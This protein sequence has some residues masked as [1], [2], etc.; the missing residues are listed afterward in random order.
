MRKISYN[1]LK[2]LIVS[3]AVYAEAAEIEKASFMFERITNYLEEETDLNYNHR[4]NSMSIINELM[5]RSDNTEVRIRSFAL[6]G[7]WALILLLSSLWPFH[8]SN[9]AKREREKDIFALIERWQVIHR[10]IYLFRLHC[11]A[12]TF[13]VWI[14]NRIELCWRILLEMLGWNNDVEDVNWLRMD[15]LPSLCDKVNEKH[16]NSIQ[17]GGFLDKQF[18]KIISASRTNYYFESFVS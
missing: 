1:L 8:Y 5:P 3:P 7:I 17:G 9:W 15:L 14:E 11:K 18:L 2:D 4:K 13:L 10:G 6:V 12:P 16:S